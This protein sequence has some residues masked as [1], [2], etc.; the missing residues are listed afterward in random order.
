MHCTAK[1]EQ[2]Q[3]QHMHLVVAQPL[4][5]SNLFM[6]KDASGTPDICEAVADFQAQ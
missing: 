3:Q 5:M 6:H 2:Q 4:M 1:A